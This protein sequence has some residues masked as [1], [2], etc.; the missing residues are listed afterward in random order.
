MKESSCHNTK[1]AAYCQEVHQLEDKFDGLEINHIPRHLN[2]AAIM[3]AK[4]VP[5]ESR[6][7]WASL[8]VTVQALGLL[9]GARTN[10]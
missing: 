8:L 6:C 3:L 2:E 10:R 7:Q 9:R 1:M 4:T 5:T